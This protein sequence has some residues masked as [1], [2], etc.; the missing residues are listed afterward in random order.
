M[1]LHAKRNCEENYRFSLKENYVVNS[2]ADLSV[3]RKHSG[4]YDDLECLFQD[5]LSV[6]FS[7]AAGLMHA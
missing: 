6:N 1:K 3:I 5:F 4:I 7:P 2:K